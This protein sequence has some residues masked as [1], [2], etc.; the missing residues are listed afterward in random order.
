MKACIRFLL[1]FVSAVVVSFNATAA[2]EE[3]ALTVPEM[4]DF[5]ELAYFIED[6]RS[7]VMIL[8]EL[9]NLGL[10]PSALE[11]R[12]A[13]WLEYFS[14]AEAQKSLQKGLE[15]GHKGCWLDATL[16]VRYAESLS[17]RF[18]NSELQELFPKL[19]AVIK[20]ETRLSVEGQTAEAIS[21][22]IR[23]RGCSVG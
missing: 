12:Q 14:L 11:P 6:T 4:N 3:R 22:R 2:Q 1:V 16:H 17:E 8:L 7:A 13:R 10:T 20:Q 18:P 19:R 9:E 21:Q 5:I 23:S 15:S